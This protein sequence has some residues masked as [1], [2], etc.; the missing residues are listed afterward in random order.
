MLCRQRST[1][2]ALQLRRNIGGSG[3]SLSS[4]PIDEARALNYLGNTHGGLG[5]AGGQWYIFYHRQTNQHSYSR[6]ACA[7]A[8]ERDH[9]GRFLQAEVTSCG[10]NGASLRE[11]GEYPAYIACMLWSRNGVARYDRPFRKRRH[12]FIT[13]F[14]RDG[15]PAA[16]QYIANMRDGAVAGFRYFDIQN[17]RHI[18]VAVGGRCRGTLEV[19]HLQDFSTLAARI[20]LSAKGSI[21]NISAVLTLP[22]GKQALFFRFKGKGAMNFYAFEMT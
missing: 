18:R 14:G 7:E 22:K 6:Q 12:P 10:L 9:E 19:S 8:L 1:G 4:R 11:T 5:R 15:D 21:K 2:W 20:S 13:Q 3:R 17:V 16:I